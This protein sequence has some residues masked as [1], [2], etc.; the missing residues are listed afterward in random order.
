MIGKT[1]LFYVFALVTACLAE[2]DFLSA[3]AGGDDSAALRSRIERRFDVFPLRDGA[4]LRPRDPRGFGSVEVSGGAIAID[5]KPVTGAELREKL[6]ADA[7]LVLRLSY[8][9]DADRRA[10]FGAPR[11]QQPTAETPPPLAERPRAERESRRERRARRANRDQDRVRIGGSVSVAADE[12]VEG[13][14]VAI[15]GS[16]SV[17]GEVH[18]DVVAVGG[19]ITLGPRASVDE[20]VV[21][22]GGVLNRDPSARIGGRIQ[23]IGV[24]PF[25]MGRWAWA[26]PLVG[27]WGSMVG[28]AFA[29]VATLARL[30]ILCL[31]SALVVLLGHDYMEKVGMRAAAEPVKAGIIGLLAQLLFLPALVITIVVFVITIIGIPLLI[32]IPFALLGLLVV[33]LVGF[34]GVA[35]R[36][37]GLVSSRLGW[38][39]DN[40]Y[41]V[42]I[43]GVVLLMAPVL[44]ARVAGLGGGVMFPMTFAL[45]LIGAA[46]EYLAWTVGFGAVALSRFARPPMLP[47]APAAPVV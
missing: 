18:G 43:T 25:R 42:T 23:Q 11:D 10:L 15:G 26:G 12:V 17:D 28:G 16:A 6:G 35:Y 32:L 2:G 13:D 30:V 4:L 38:P 20:N 46:V 8:L 19:N 27:R 5:G 36:L 3:Q 40:R 33:A 37:G 41:R 24:G 31:F 21:V 22:V 14:V 47:P 34:A 9:S 1:L 7:E 39:S 44:L 45:G 29:F